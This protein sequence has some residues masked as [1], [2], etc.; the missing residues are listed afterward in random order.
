MLKKLVGKLFGFEREIDALREQVSAL[1]WDST[2]GMWTREAFQQLCQVM[3]R[4]N[5]VIAFIDIDDVHGMNDRWGYEEVNQRIK[6]AFSVYF[7]RSDIVARWFS[8]DEI[9]ILF[10]SGTEGAVHK[11][12]Q[13]KTSAERR[14]ITF[15]HEVGEWQVGREAIEE[16]IHRLATSVQAQKAEKKK[17]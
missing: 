10:D 4:G 9:V 12:E 7:R 8:G 15:V 17:E 11:L 13:L 5:R 16:T 14:D 2:F 6:D 1:R 3:P